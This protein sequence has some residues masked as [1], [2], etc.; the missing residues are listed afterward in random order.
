MRR[1]LPTLFGSLAAQLGEGE[2][3]QREFPP[4]AVAS[5]GR[6]HDED[7]RQQQATHGA[8]IRKA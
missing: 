4:Q 5:K 6:A 8:P 7:P 2:A 1:G 3:E